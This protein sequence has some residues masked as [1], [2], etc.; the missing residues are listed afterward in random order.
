H[1]LGSFLADHVKVELFL[2]LARRRNVGEKCLGHASPLPLLVEDLLAQLDTIAAD[3]HVARPLHQGADIA[4]ALA[5]EGAISIL[6][7]AARVARAHVATAISSPPSGATSS[8]VLTRWHTFSLS[9]REVSD[10]MP[11]RPQAVT[12]TSR[13]QLPSLRRARA[14]PPPVD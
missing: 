2:D 1:L 11:R 6:L 5:A 4:I 10:S 3:V 12:L 9:S 7:W 14:G 8:D 13:C